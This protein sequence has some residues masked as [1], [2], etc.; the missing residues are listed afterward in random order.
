MK[1]RLTLLVTPAVFIA[2]LLLLVRI[3]DLLTCA[4]RWL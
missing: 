1:R 4:L 2:S 3:G